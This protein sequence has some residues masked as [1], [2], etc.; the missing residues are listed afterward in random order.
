M[1]SARPTFNEWQ[2]TVLNNLQD[3]CQGKRRRDRAGEN[4][5]GNCMGLARRRQRGVRCI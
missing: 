3:V 2:N 1:M 4:E 5:D